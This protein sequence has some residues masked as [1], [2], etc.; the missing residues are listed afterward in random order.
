MKHLLS[1]AFLL[2][3]SHAFVVPLSRTDVG[4]ALNAEMGRRNFAEAAIIAVGSTAF[5]NVAPAFARGEDYV[6]KFDDLKQIYI[7]V[8][9]SKGSA[10]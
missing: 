7:L 6:P 9:N 2:A 5:V 1:A 8:R 4:T 10:Y 3:S